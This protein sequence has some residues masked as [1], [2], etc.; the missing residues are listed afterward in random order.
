MPELPDVEAV[1]QYLLS[2]G[3]VGRTITGAELHW[4]RAVRTPSEEE[5]KSGISGRRI[6]KIGRR[7][8]YLV[9]GLASRPGRT[10]IIH[11]RMTGSL[12][13]LPVGR[14]RPRHTRNVILLAGD[15]ELCFVDPRKLGMMW[16][17]RDEDEVLGGLGPEPLAPSFTREV[18][19]QALSGRDA[20]VKALLCDQAIVAGIGNIYA[21]EVLFLAGIHPLIRGGEI[22]PA[23][24][25]R[26]HEAIVSRLRD[27]TELMMPLVTGGGPP[28]AAEQ[29]LTRLLVPRSEGAPCSRCGSPVSRVVVRGR[30]SYF[31]PQCQGT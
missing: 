18:L 23:H 14:E 5:F 7:G 4:P 2:Q 3:L 11:L 15:S 13:M 20:P 30:S 24:N 6:R 12:L 29:G 31:C 28:T 1:R 17:V 26:L 10:L 27:A 19:A 9:V 25:H 16:L 21:D 8:K 22:S